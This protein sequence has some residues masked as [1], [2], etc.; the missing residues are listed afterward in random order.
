MDWWWTGG[1]GGAEK[2]VCV[3]RDTGQVWLSSLLYIYFFLKVKEPR[4]H[5]LYIPRDDIAGSQCA[6]WSCHE[7]RY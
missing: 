2:L 3:R 6:S 5:L 1:G 4:F 7:L